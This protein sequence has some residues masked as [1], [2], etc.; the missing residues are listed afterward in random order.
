MCGSQ[1][2]RTQWA[3]L[4]PSYSKSKLT[5]TFW[6]YLVVRKRKTGKTKKILELVTR[7]TLFWMLLSWWDTGL[8]RPHW[9]TT[10]FISL[11]AS[12]FNPRVK[13]F[14][15]VVNLEDIEF[16]LFGFVVERQLR[17]S[18]KPPERAAWHFRISLDTQESNT[19]KGKLPFVIVVFS[20]LSREKQIHPCKMDCFRRYC[21]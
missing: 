7:T 14:I 2:G 16:L 12:Y 20:V 18:V 10:I 6:L 13:Y 15:A 17:K 5:I 9:Q 4:S 21:C 8:A 1:I 3:S 19:V 11:S